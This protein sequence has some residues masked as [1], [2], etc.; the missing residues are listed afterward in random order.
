MAPS[1]GLLERIRA[2]LKTGKKDEV[3]TRWAKAFDTICPEPAPSM[4]H[5]GLLA[6]ISEAIQSG[7]K[8]NDEA[9][10]AIDRCLHA[11]KQ[12]PNWTAAITLG[13]F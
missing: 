1:V 13:V 4:P 6:K 3:V 8:D 7:K 10:S 9:N 12:T 2:A 11:A 5:A